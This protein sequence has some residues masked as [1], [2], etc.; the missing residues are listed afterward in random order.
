MS[1]PDLMPVFLLYVSRSGSTFLTENIA[2]YI[3]DVC[4]MPE[5]EIFKPLLSR[6]K[7]KF[8]LFS[9]D[10]WAR[11]IIEDERM[12][13]TGL[14]EVE[15]AE[16]FR[17]DHCRSIPDVVWSL[18]R[19]YRD[20]TDPNAQF[21]LI[22]RG[23]NMH[24]IKYITHHFPKSR[25]LMV[26]RDP[27]AVTRSQITQARVYTRSNFPMGRGDAKYIATHWKNY[28]RKF[29]KLTESGELTLEIPYER[30]VADPPAAMKVVS[31]WLG[32][33]VN[34]LEESRTQGI[35]LSP[36]EE[37]TLHKRV[38][39]AAD[40]SRIDTWRTELSPKTVF[41]IEDICE[42]EMQTRGYPPQE[43]LHTSPLRAAV[44]RLQANLRSFSIASRY[45][46]ER[47]L[48][49]LRKQ[50]VRGVIQSIRLRAKYRL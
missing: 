11:W 45:Y 20:K 9:P 16:S 26:Y 14:T 4:A 33:T 19:L 43:I 36:V 32:V 3:P 24:F 47:F 10:D 25:Y 18:M 46:L 28:V 23:S 35:T 5:L 34:D 42:K 48:F 38:K 31:N 13:N 39:Q 12:T 1:K 8:S 27:R 29:E 41:T 2:R 6:G 37:A 17:K 22:K 50:G 44:L 49:R 30:L 40:E 21:V 7:G 15:L